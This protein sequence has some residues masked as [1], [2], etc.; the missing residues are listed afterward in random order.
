MYDWKWLLGDFSNRSTNLMKAELQKIDYNLEFYLD[1][2]VCE[3]EIAKCE[4]ENGTFH[5]KIQ[6]LH[7][8]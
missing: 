4:L 3:N 7:Q 6:N 2:E 8:K 5:S 1:N